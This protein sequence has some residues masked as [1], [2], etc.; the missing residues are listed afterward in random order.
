MFCVSIGKFRAH[1]RTNYKVNRLYINITLFLPVCTICFLL[2][3][4]CQNCTNFPFLQK[5]LYFLQ[6]SC[7]NIRKISL[8][9]RLHT[10][11]MFF[12]QNCVLSKYFRPITAITQY[13]AY[14]FEG[15]S[16]VVLRE[17][18]SPCNTFFN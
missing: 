15:N 11:T 5:K 12:K 7:I 6:I 3:K 8:Y 2:Q 1:A 10:L 4:C 13:R 14:S 18:K 16:I 17:F 9:D